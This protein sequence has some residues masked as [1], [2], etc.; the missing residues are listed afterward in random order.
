VVG[1][2]QEAALQVTCD[3]AITAVLRARAAA[4]LQ[5]YFIVAEVEV[6]EGDETRVEVRHTELEKCPRCWNYREFAA[7][8]EVCERCAAVLDEI[9]FA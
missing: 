2:S 8:R 7:G 4:T 3:P 5:E 9:G 1:K 6:I